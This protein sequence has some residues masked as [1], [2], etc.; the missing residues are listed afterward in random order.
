MKM[1]V[2]YILDLLENSLIRFNFD[3]QVLK[4]KWNQILQSNV[5]IEITQ[6][7]INFFFFQRVA[8]LWITI[9]LNI[10]YAPRYIIQKYNIW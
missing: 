3:I 10:S 2:N 5:L 4:Y 7:I 8:Q 9:E 1:D 6:D